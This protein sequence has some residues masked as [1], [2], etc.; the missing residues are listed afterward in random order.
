MPPEPDAQYMYQLILPKVKMKSTVVKATFVNKPVAV[1]SISGLWNR[2]IKAVSAFCCH[3]S[4]VAYKCFSLYYDIFI[5]RN[6][7]LIH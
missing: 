3:K 2:R 5:K 1:L 7:R 4:Y 6:K